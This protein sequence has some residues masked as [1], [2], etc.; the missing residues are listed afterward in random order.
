MEVK[1]IAAQM[2]SLRHELEKSPEETFKSLK[3]IGFK[4][5][6]LDGMRGHDPK[7]I[8]ELV[9]KYNFEIAGM[10]IKHERFFN[11]IDGIVA[12]ALLFGSKVIYDKYIDDEEQHREGYIKTKNQL[13]K[14]QDM[15][16]PL[17]FQVGLHC[18][19]YDFNEKIDS[20]TVLDYIT[21]PEI[22]LSILSEPDTY[23]MSVAGKNP[24]EEIKKFH[25]RAPIIHLK[26]YIK[27]FD[28]KDMEH[29]LTELGKGDVDFKAI[30]EWGKASG[31][32]YYCIEQDYS[33]IG[34]FNSMQES[35][36]YLRNL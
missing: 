26:D 9:K 3:E 17:G 14:V 22:G 23:W 34:M 8:N 24:V 30:I 19:E 29:N 11:D 2:Y 15:L 32:E 31:V 1:K 7:E 28:P 4:A 33:H 20:K 6:Q 21:A 27:G 35:F 10:H 5:I 36:D 25:N 13:L 16:R 12:E 18:P